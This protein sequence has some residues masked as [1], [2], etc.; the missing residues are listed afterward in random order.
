MIFLLLD[1]QDDV[2]DRRLARHL[3]SLYY[4]RSQ[5][6]DEYEFMDIA[7]LK[8]YI[9][10]A[11]QNVHPILTEE[12]SQALIH[13]Y[14]EMRKAGSGRGLISAY[15]RQLESLIRLSEAHAKLRLSNTV[16]MEDVEEAKRLHREAIKQSATDPSTG[17]IDVSILTTGVTA[18]GRKRRSEIAK[19][20]KQHILTLR[21]SSQESPQFGYQ[22]LYNTFKEVSDLMV[23]REMF[24]DALKDL[25]DEG[26]LIVMGQK[27]IR[28][29]A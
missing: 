22:S 8:D 27:T 10:Y 18:T 24:E 23:T 11:R 17:I 13:A 21:G 2:Y 7:L 15:P 1:P 3:V 29:C 20:L 26:Y 25:S 19:A 12:A 4:H 16:E 28:L 14:V 6:E 9:G 5:E